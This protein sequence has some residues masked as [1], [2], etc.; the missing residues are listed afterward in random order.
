MNAYR[1]LHFE[2]TINIGLSGLWAYVLNGTKASIMSQRLDA[3]ND[4]EYIESVGM[5]PYANENIHSERLVGQLRAHEIDNLRARRVEHDARDVGG[6][7]APTGDGIPTDQSNERHPDDH[8][9]DNDAD[10]EDEEEYNESQHYPPEPPP[11]PGHPHDDGNDDDAEWRH[12]ND[13]NWRTSSF[14]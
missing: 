3:K 12:N 2:S 10:A 5:L 13:H 1:D 7:I 8:S 6:A 9:S 14:S 4:W 11:P